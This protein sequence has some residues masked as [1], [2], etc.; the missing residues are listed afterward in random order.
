M[1]LQSFIQLFYVWKSARLTFWVDATLF[2][3][4]FFK[5]QTQLL[6]FRIMNIEYTKSVEMM[7]EE[8]TAPYVT[9]EFKRKKH[10][11]Q[12][13]L[14]WMN[15]SKCKKTKR[16]LIRGVMPYGIAHHRS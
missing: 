15:I 10:T 2:S 16:Y 3:S 7:K 9:L 4:I 5:E 8:Y 11:Q 1:I 14:T 13:H 12:I 6:N